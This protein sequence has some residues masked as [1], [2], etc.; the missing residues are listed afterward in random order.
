MTSR[1]VLSKKALAVRAHFPADYRKHRSIDV[2]EL[3]AD[4]RRKIALLSALAD[5]SARAEESEE[6]SI[7]ISGDV[8][9]EMF[10]TLGTIQESVDRLD[11]HVATLEKA[12]DGKKGGAR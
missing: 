11:R 12:A 8:W 1:L 4:A 9:R 3:F 5:S 6:V 7:H 10:F 2:E